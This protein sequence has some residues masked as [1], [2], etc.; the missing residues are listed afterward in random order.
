MTTTSEAAIPPV[1]QPEL[2][3]E[4]HQPDPTST[5]VPSDTVAG[6]EGGDA[7]AAETPVEH[8]RRQALRARLYGYAIAAVVLVSVVI[9]LAASNT[10]PVR[11]DWLA[12]SSRVSLVLLVLVAAVLGWG[13]GLLAGA[14]FH[15]L[16]RAP[17]GQ[18][19]A[20]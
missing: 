18:R 12:G 1:D 20:R 9:M 11:V 10:A 16:T 8:F 15:W 5:A 2:D 6:R 19:K 14:R 17:R 13:L 4:P 3:L 7:L